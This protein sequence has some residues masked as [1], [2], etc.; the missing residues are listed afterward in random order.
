MSKLT[1]SA[2]RSGNITPSVANSGAGQGSASTNQNWGQSTAAVQGT[3]SLT[4]LHNT[5]L[6]VAALVLVAG[7]G[8][9]GLRKA[10]FRFSFDAGFGK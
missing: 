7:G 4:G 3:G 6:H 8:L 10:G 9:W 5:P 1:N 2:L